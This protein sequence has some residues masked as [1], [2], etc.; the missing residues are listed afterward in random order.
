MFW[1]GKAMSHP[2]I[3][4]SDYFLITVDTI[5]EL[6]L[7]DEY[8]QQRDLLRDYSNVDDY[9]ATEEECAE[10]VEKICTIAADGS[11][12]LM[13]F[14]GFMYQSSNLDTIWYLIKDTIYHYTEL[15]AMEILSK[16]ED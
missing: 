1:K 15:A 6:M 16:K 2:S 13:P 8:D 9:E 4:L 11:D 12:N 5:R 10:L 3:T 14:E 7:W